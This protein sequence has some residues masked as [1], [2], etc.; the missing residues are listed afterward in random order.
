MKPEKQKIDPFIAS[1][2]P[3]SDK[4]MSAI[5]G[6]SL[7]VALS[8]SLLAS[9]YERMVDE[10][11]FEKT[12][13]EAITATLDVME[14]KTEKKVQPKETPKTENIRRRVGS[15]GKPKG[16]GNPHAPTSRGVL[17]ELA[18][19]TRNATASAYDYMRRATAKDVDKVLTKINGLQKN[20]TSAI[21]ERR[22]KVGSEFNSGFAAGGSGGVEGLL[23]GL[24]GGPAGT[25]KTKAMGKFK[26][27]TLRDIDMGT[28]G[29]S[30]SASD[31]MKVVRQRTPGLRHV[32]NTY[33]KKKPGF[34]GKVTLRFVIAPGGDIISNAIVSSTTGFAEFDNAI[35]KA[36]SSWT[37]NKVK[38]GN[39]TVTIP[40]TFS[41]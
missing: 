5:A 35:K 24:L 4:K 26:A 15:G 38:S 25:I 7:L 27:P 28:G 29:G 41:E 17:L 19:F 39:T 23:N 1:L 30:R 6:T 12:E 33:L 40:F 3:D 21:G 8:L 20:G 11:I 9:T 14:K 37:F 10:L 31:I 16:N 18:A 32:Y 13:A 2:M 22:G 34:Q 36:V